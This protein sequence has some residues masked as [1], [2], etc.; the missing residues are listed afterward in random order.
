[1]IQINAGG[2]GLNLQNFNT[3]Y[4]TSPSWNPSLKDQAIA[5]AHRI[6]QTK[7]VTVHRFCLYDSKDEISTIDQRNSCIQ[8]Q[9]RDL[10][11]E[12]LND[13]HLKNVGNIDTSKITNKSLLY[14]LTTSD[15]GQLLQKFFL[16]VLIV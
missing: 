11:A 6:G 16:L 7:A 8:A 5:R 10:M 2:V 13:I 14:K 15:I 9:K 1:M 12:Y 4:F 3:V